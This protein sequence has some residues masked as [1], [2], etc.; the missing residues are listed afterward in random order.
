VIRVTRFDGS[1]FFVNS[2]LIQT[3]ESKPDTHI[4]L[5]TGASYLVREADVE[6]VER[7]VAFRRSIARPDAGRQAKLTLLPRRVGAQP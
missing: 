5:T 6:I 3:V 7:V 1:E 4:V 2:D